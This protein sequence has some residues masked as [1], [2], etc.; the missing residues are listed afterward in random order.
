[1]TTIRIDFKGGVV[2]PE[3]LRVISAVLNDFSVPEIFIGTRQNIYFHISDNLSGAL[4]G[5]L[6]N[7]RIQ[8]VILPAGVNNIV[9]SYAA[10]DIFTHNSW[11]N[12]SIFK[13]VLDNFNESSAY[14]INIVDISQGL[15]TAFEGD[16]VF[17][18]SSHQNFWYLFIRNTVNEEFLCWPDLIY[19]L[20]LGPV[21]GH[22]EMYA[23]AINEININKIHD[24]IKAELHYIFHS[25]DVELK[26][27]RYI[28]ANYEGIHR[29]G[30][31]SWIGIK[32]KSDSYPV[33]FINGLADLCTG[34][35]V[36]NINLTTWKSILI[37]NISEDDII[38]WEIL[39][40]KYGINI[41]H[42][43]LELIWKYEDSDNTALSLKKY[44]IE[45][46]DKTDVRS[47]GI[48]FGI[49]TNPNSKIAASII[50]EV[51]S[52]AKSFG[53]PFFQH[54]NV[55]HTEDFN[56]NNQKIYFVGVYKSK[57]NLVKNIKLLLT[58]YY[59][60]LED[61]TVVHDP[62]PKKETQYWT[63]QRAHKCKHCYTIYDSEFGDI[64]N[65][66]EP[67]ISFENLPENYAC[68]LCGAPKEEFLTV[69]KILSK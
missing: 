28:P 21:A 31:L 24:N 26:I 68:S 59:K 3:K 27:P 45:E 15:F 33:S 9:S 42:S 66:I 4:T 49:K 6:D 43:S 16:L 10:V 34:T 61:L 23:G 52:S 8:Y 58:Q 64:I 13:E 17:I 20:E 54:Y 5:K 62:V 36:N 44:L 60:S 55:Y 39:L 25:N 65:G 57:R 48:T 69:R 37:K 12:E 35:N 18:P 22:L 40:G 11:L 50:I 38:K 14:K 53:T 19:S 51:K 67:G 46:L 29:N 30:S 63:P 47:Y 41:R 7:S 56:P 2:S 1:M 32:N